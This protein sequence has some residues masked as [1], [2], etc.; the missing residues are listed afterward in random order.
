MISFQ[1]QLDQW[2]FSKTMTHFFYLP[3]TIVIILP[4]QLIMC[5][6]IVLQLCGAPNVWENA[7]FQI[8]TFL[9]H[10]ISASFNAI[11]V[12]LLLIPFINSDLYMV[13]LFPC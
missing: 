3:W 1:L 13:K 9:A 5:V 2:K 10:V 6:P 4:S 12:F 8:E 11:S 7:H